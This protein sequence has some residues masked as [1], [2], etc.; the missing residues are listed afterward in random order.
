[1]KIYDKYQRT[2]H[3]LA[4]INKK[5]RK[6]NFSLFFPVHGLEEFDL[7][8][9]VSKGFQECI[10]EIMVDVEYTFHSLSVNDVGRV[11]DVIPDIDEGKLIRFDLA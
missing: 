9:I 10:T 8:L 4:F 11:R 2:G 7:L 6:D 1:M 5:D 3:L